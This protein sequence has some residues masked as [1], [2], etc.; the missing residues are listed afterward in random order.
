VTFVSRWTKVRISLVGTAVLAVA[1]FGGPAFERWCP[2]I[3]AARPISANIVAGAL[4][5]PLELLVAYGLVTAVQNFRRQRRWR[6]VSAE[7]AV[8]TGS[9]WHDLR[10]LLVYQ[11]SASSL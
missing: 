5:M 9:T 6:A 10:G 11:Y 1:T 8:A 2:H 3:A 4:L 7:L